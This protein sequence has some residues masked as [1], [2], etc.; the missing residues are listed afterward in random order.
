MSLENEQ[1]AVKRM[2]DWAS[3]VIDDRSEVSNRQELSPRMRSVSEKLRDSMTSKV[4]D[5]MLVGALVSGGGFLV[6]KGHKIMDSRVEAAS[7]QLDKDAQEAA[8]QDL[9]EALSVNHVDV[10]QIN[11]ILADDELVNTYREMRTENIDSF[12]EYLSKKGYD[13]NQWYSETN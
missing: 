6:Y 8:R 5:L 3:D 10:E 9:A 1:S 11:N 12:D 4:L 2:G 7:A 13:I